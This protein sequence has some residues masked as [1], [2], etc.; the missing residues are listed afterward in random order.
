MKWRVK[1]PAKQEVKNLEIFVTFSKKKNCL[2][3]THNREPYRVY[4]EGSQLDLIKLDEIIT[5]IIIKEG[6]L[7]KIRQAFHSDD[8]II[9]A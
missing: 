6:E 9:F 7:R 5:K 2:T 4:T 3:F 8:D 1:M